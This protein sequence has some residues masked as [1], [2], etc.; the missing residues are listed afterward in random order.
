[1]RTDNIQSVIGRWRMTRL[2]YL[3]RHKPSLYNTLLLSGKLNEHLSMLNRQAAERHQRIIDQMVAKE[4]I[5]EELKSRDQMEWVRRMNAIRATA[6]E[7]ILYE[8]I[9]D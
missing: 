7:L 9:F 4:G 2:N 3:K 1:M 8:M 6:D 5:T